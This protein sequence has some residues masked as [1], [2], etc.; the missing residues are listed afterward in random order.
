[1]LP[2]DKDRGQGLQ[3]YPRLDNNADHSVG[4][5]H[6]SLEPAEVFCTRSAHLHTGRRSSDRTTRLIHDRIRS[7]AAPFQ[8]LLHD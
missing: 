2:V 3:C 4:A 5:G 1:M 6:A 8:N 7:N